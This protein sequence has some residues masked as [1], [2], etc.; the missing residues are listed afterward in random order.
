LNKNL[1]ASDYIVGFVMT[2]GK[3][4]KAILYQDDADSGT[5]KP[6]DLKKKHMKSYWDSHIMLPL[7]F[8]DF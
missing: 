1:V 3:I 2:N 6:F 7:L 8:Q 4:K 5:M